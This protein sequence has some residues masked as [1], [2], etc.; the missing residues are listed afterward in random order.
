MQKAT[1][2]RGRLSTGG[3]VVLTCPCRDCQATCRCS[4]RLHSLRQTQ[5]NWL[6]LCPLRPPPFCCQTWGRAARLSIAECRN[7]NKTNENKRGERSWAGFPPA[8]RLPTHPPQEP[9]EKATPKDR[10]R[11]EQTNRGED[12]TERGDNKSHRFCTFWDTF[13]PCQSAVQIRQKSRYCTL[14][15]FARTAKI[16]AP[17][18]CRRLVLESFNFLSNAERSTC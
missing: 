12:T 11:E 3:L 8:R 10:K 5:G 18:G 17:N 16:K 2:S 14:R 1:P 4:R 9:K 7:Q 6:R 13:Y 15:K